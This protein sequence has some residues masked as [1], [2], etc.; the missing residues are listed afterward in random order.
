MVKWICGTYLEAM[1]PS[2]T[3][4]DECKREKR[5]NK[6]KRYTEMHIIN[7]KAVNV[8]DNL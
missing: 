4:K 1:L 7:L 2:I 8:I 5:N 6:R 3:G